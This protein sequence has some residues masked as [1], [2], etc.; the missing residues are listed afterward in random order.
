LLDPKTGRALVEGGSHLLEPTEALIKG[1]ALPGS[2]VNA[3]AICVGARLEM[4]VN[5]KVF[6]TSP[7]K[8]VEVKQN[9]A[10][11]SVESISA[12]LH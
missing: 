9:A 12:A 8:S 6:L 2:A 10:A 4:W 7:I 1:S 3:G 11:E 5:E